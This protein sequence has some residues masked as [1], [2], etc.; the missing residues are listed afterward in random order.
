MPIHVAGR[1]GGVGHERTGVAP[2]ALVA[3]DAGDVIKVGA[4]DVTL[5]HT[6]GHTPGSQCILVEGRLIS[7][8]TLFLDGCGR[9]D[10]P[11]G[12]RGAMY[13]LLDVGVW[14]TWTTTT[15]SS[16]DT[17][18]RRN[19][20]LAHGRR[21]RAQRGLRPGR[22]SSSGSPC[23]RVEGP[24]T[25][26]ITWSSSARASPAGESSRGCAARGSTGQITLVGEESRAPY[27][28]PPLSK[29]VLSCKWDVDKATW[30]RPS[31]RRGAASRSCLGAASGRTSTL[32]RPRSRSTTAR[33]VTGPASSS[34]RGRGRAPL[35]SVRARRPCAR[36]RTPRRWRE[37]GSI[38]GRAAASSPSSAEVSSARRRRQRPS[39]AGC[40]PVVLEAAPRPLIGVLGESV[41]Q[42]L[43]QVPSDPGSSCAPVSALSTWFPDEGGYDSSSRTARA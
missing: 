26:T 5:V 13:A 33:A 37:G 18:T 29:Q 24:R 41:A 9:T 38:A 39:P 28:R 15:G 19:R 10:L 8:D 3:H 14:A 30:P 27:D 7:G 42:W 32:S 11:G 6:P 4:F 17:C 25:T 1:R 21:A 36:R 34:P 22:A 16:R 43:A 40:V 31:A 35:R 23:S 20:A 2:E 12:D